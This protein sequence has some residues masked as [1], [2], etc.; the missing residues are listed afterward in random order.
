MTYIVI[1]LQTAA[2]GAVGVI[3]DSYTNRDAAEQKYHTV[4]SFSAV[5]AL[6]T[7]AAVMITGDGQLIKREV[8]H[9]E[10]QGE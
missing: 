2:N 1:E 4:L 5:S 6:P 7:H 3:T 8:Y 9:H 10:E